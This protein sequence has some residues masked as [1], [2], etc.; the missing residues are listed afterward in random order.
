M[1]VCKNDGVC[2]CPIRV[3]ERGSLN[4]IIK[5]CVTVI[6]SLHYGLT[7]TKFSLCIP[8]L[9]TSTC[10]FF[11]KKFVPI[12]GTYGGSPAANHKVSSKQNSHFFIVVFGRVLVVVLFYVFLCV[13]PAFHLKAVI[14]IQAAK[15]LKYC[16][17][18]H[19][20]SVILKL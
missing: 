9:N 8:I 16:R 17:L 15:Y 3:H 20:A 1:R 10:T 19:F 14:W 2:F 4:H 6:V 12:F 5:V 18:L 13:N 11:L 7:A